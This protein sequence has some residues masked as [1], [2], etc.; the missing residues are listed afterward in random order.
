MMLVSILLW[1]LAAI[2]NAIMDTLVHH[3]Y[4]SIFFRMNKYFWNPEESWLHATR[5]PILKYKLDAFHIFKSLMIIFQSLAIMCAWIGGP[6]L[7]DI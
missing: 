2:C 1:C 6:P 5:I 7:L 3:Y 4:T